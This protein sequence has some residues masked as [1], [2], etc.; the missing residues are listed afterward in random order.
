MHKIEKHPEHKGL[1]TFDGCYDK[2]LKV[3]QEVVISPSSLI[4]DD[5]KVLVL[6][7]FKRFK[8][9]EDRCKE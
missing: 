9:I 6:C 4:S 3:A 5:E 8:E 7:S 1:F 2:F